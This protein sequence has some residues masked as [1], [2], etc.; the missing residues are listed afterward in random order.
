M[1]ILNKKLYTSLAAGVVMTFSMVMPAQ[2]VLVETDVFGQINSFNDADGFNLSDWTGF[3]GLA[4]ND[5]VQMHVVWD[6]AL[7]TTS[8]AMP[9]TENVA[10]DS[11]IIEFINNMGNTA[12]T[13]VPLNTAADSANNLFF[14]DG[15]LQ[16]FNLFACLGEIVDGCTPGGALVIDY[17]SGD[18]FGGPLDTHLFTMF[19]FDS[20]D[21]ILNGEFSLPPG[22]ITPVAVIPVPAA[23]W[24]F[25][26]G[27][28]GLIGI[29]R[30][31]RA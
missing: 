15:L 20:D 19:D 9:G 23:V 13:F 26:S 18:E 28:I 1:G 16:G 17:V 22:T 29:A 4:V 5:T 10:F 21:V 3:Q 7:V 24:L 30:R 8:V 31:R 11:I 6:D 14:Q 12:L 25:G 2:A 27:L